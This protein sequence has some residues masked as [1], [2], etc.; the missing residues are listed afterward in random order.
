[1]VD[2]NGNWGEKW[3]ANTNQFDN[4]GMLD[5][6]QTKYRKHE[7]QYAHTGYSFVAFV[8]SSFGALGPSAIRYLWALAMLELRQHEALRQK[9]GLDPLIESERAQYRANCYRSSTARVAAAMA[10]AT[11]MRLS[12]T[13]SIPVFDQVPRQLLAHNLPGIS[14]FRDQRQAPRAAPSHPAPPLPTPPNSHPPAFAPPLD[15]RVAPS[16]SLSPADLLPQSP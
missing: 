14:D 4:P 3:N 6:E 11:V 15:I 1:M 10:K 16:Y 8:C 12:G 7:A 13:P 5:A 9:Q 2:G